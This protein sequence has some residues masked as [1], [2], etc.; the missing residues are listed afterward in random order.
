MRPTLIMALCILTLGIIHCR[1]NLGENMD[2]C[3][4]RFGQPMPSSGLIDP[5]QLGGVASVFHK[6]G[7]EFEESKK[8]DIWLC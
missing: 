7:Y 8:R 2:Q 4:L 6:N 1:A 5:P 3:V